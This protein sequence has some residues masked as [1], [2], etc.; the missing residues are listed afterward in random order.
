MTRI[1]GFH[2]HGLGSME[3]SHGIECGVV[4]VKQC[5]VDKKKK[6][7]K[8]KKKGKVYDNQNL[9]RYNL[10]PP[11]EPVLCVNFAEF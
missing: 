10:Y 9:L 11:I 7:K 3:L 2:G 4:S 8:L 6:E 5:G 1:L